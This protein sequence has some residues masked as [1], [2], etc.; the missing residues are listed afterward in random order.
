MLTTM[1][2]GRR[3]RVGGCKGDW[4]GGRRQ[5]DGNRYQPTEDEVA[6]KNRQRQCNNNEATMT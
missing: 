6:G 2:P 5:R 1:G 3:D 4:G